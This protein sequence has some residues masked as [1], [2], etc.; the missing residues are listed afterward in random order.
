[1]VSILVI[2]KS[3][4]CIAIGSY[5]IVATLPGTFTFVALNQLNDKT[6]IPHGVYSW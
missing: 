3:D 6:F 4:S 2:I 5:S 1:M